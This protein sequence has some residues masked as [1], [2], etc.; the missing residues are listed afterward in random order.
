MIITGTGFVDV[1]AVTFG[2]T[3]AA[4]TVDSPTQITATAPAHAVG[5]VQV[6]VTA[7]GLS[8]ADT[9]AD[10]Y[11]YSSTTNY[12]ERASVATGGAQ[13]S[14]SS[15]NAAISSNGRYV[16]F[17]SNAGNLVANDTNGTTDS[18]IYDRQ[19]G[20]IERVSVSTAGV[21]GN[22]SSTAPAVSA[23]GRYVAFTSNATNLVAGDTNGK[24]DVFVRDRQ[25]GTTELVSLNGD[26]VTLSNGRQLHPDRQCR[27]P[28]RV[29]LQQ[30][31]QPGCR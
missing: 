27:R 16:V 25:A 17:W 9:A 7:G 11:T 23:D 15:G 19:T 13:A 26:D 2:G 8:S 29:L 22:G 4:Y 1:T 18:Y 28:L 20:A 12:T 3:T 5:S 6:Q 30:R 31:H 24:A 10:D 14:S 21:Q